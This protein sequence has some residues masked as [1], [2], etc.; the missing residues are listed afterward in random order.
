[1]AHPAKKMTWNIDFRSIYPIWIPNRNDG[2]LRG[3][4]PLAQPVFHDEGS[5]LRDL[6][7]NRETFFS[8]SN[9]AQEEMRKDQLLKPDVESVLRRCPVVRVEMNSGEE[10][11]NV[12][13]RDTDG[14]MIEVV[15]VAYEDDL[16]I[17]I[18]STWHLKE[19]R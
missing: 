11:W 7:N 16:R 8:Y 13:G 9:H 6:A 5:R 17:K 12:R 15:V 1:M 10:S 4:N 19:H 18:L 2:G 14:R 3:G